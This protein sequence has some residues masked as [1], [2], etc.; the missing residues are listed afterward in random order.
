MEWNK[1]KF[2]FA[3]QALKDGTDQRTIDEYLMYAENLFGQDLPII[4][5]PVHFSKLVGLKGQY[6]YLMSQTPEKYYRTFNILKKNGNTRMISEPLPDLKMLQR[7]ILLEILH[8]VPVSRFS[9]AFSKG[10][11]I[12]DNAR[13]HQNQSCVLSVDIKDFFPS[14]GKPK[15]Y[16]LFES[17]GYSSVVSTLLT[18]LCCLHDGL[19]QGAPTSPQL[20]NL[21]FRDL[22]QTIADYCL[23]NSLRYSRYADDI[24]ISGNVDVK[25]TLRFLYGVLRNGGF[26]MNPDKTRVA[27]QNARQEVT[28]IVVNKYM[29]VPLSERRELRK[30]MY[31][32]N[33]FGIDSHLESIGEMRSNYLAH[34]MGRIN[35]ALFVNPKDKEM[36]RYLLDLRTIDEE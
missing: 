18:N 25:S 14:I 34:L 22:D 17:L 36:K 35:H 9:K 6:V 10:S 26:S 5:S 16:L 19:P 1:Y 15:I 20:S 13:L 28:G 23:S 12:K 11:S 31:Y 33:K 29:Q 24:T 7:W 2:L 27:R 21:I 8:Q 4:Y 30:I 32:I 3:H